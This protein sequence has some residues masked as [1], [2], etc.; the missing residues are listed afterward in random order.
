MRLAR[1]GARRG[2][3]P[4]PAAPR[5]PGGCLG[6]DSALGDMPLTSPFQVQYSKRYISKL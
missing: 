6:T 5:R 3:S 1:C 4:G 2:A